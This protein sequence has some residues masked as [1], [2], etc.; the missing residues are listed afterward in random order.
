MTGPSTP[1][2]P[3]GLLAPLAAV[4]GLLAVAACSAGPGRLALP[5]PGPGACGPG[6]GARG[7]RVGTLT[8]VVDRPVDPR[9]L[10]RARSLAERLAGRHLYRS[11]VRVDCRG[12]ILP[13]LAGS[14]EREDDGKRWRIRLRPATAPDG[15]PIT[16]GDVVRS[17]QVSGLRTG[18]GTA[19]LLS[20]LRVEEESRRALVAAG[21][22]S[23]ATPAVFARPRF[24][25]FD[26][27][28]G[29]RWPGATGPYRLARAAGRSPPGTDDSETL[30]L[31]PPPD[32]R[33]PVLEIAPAGPERARDLVDAGADLVLTRNPDLLAYAGAS[34]ELSTRPLPWDRIHLLLLPPA[35]GRAD[36]S[37]SPSAQRDSAGRA[38]ARAGLLRSLARYAVRGP[39]RPAP[40]RGWWRAAACPEPLG[41]PRPARPLPPDL[42]VLPRGPGSGPDSLR[43]IVRPRESGAA[44]DLAGRLVA[45]AGREGTV[46]LPWRRG[47]SPVRTRPLDRP[48]FRRALARGT[49]VGYLLPARHRVLH[50]C[51]AR[52]SLLRRAPW[53][54]RPGARIVP[55]VL[56]RPGLAVRRD[57]R[58]VRLDW[59]GIPRLDDVRRRGEP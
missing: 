44:G 9:R 20:G 4:A 26:P 37:E 28:G 29:G 41:R 51:D 43:E 19:G 24:G 13:D 57:L 3:T 53:L 56:T 40:G 39:A 49:S 32:R 30:V 16:G 36:G 25:V 11:L 21:A 23:L 45:L 34:G 15:D 42:D 33:A 55:L 59:D 8:V 35:A 17:W 10:P 31:L 7:A 54:A 47:W 48:A 52:L 18:A 12:R 14:W 1:R 2:S 38:E 58:G 22:H 6:D 27:R 5:S 50:G 46:P